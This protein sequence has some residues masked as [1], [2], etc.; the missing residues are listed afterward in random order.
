MHLC[1]ASAVPVPVN[2]LFLVLHK[3]F[4]NTETYCNDEVCVWCLFALRGVQTS[5]GLYVF[6]R[7]RAKEREKVNSGV[8]ESDYREEL[9]EEEEEHSFYLIRIMK[10]IIM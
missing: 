2:E 6:I 9:Q 5:P 10:V 8:D 1:G 7:R 3:Y 4:N